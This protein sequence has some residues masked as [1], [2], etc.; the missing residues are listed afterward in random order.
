MHRY[1]HHVPAL[2]QTLQA[3]LECSQAHTIHVLLPEG[4]VTQPTHMSKPGCRAFVN[5]HVPVQLCT[6]TD[7]W[8]MY[9]QY[10]HEQPCR[11]WGAARLPAVFALCV[12]YARASACR[13]GC[14]L[15]QS[16]Y[17]HLLP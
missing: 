1:V 5:S 2:T 6:L 15:V 13:A 4:W 8:K 11:I 17:M 10:L 7:T 9:P 3:A 12:Q 14:M 16:Q